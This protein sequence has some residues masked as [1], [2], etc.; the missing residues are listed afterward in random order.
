MLIQLLTEHPLAALTIVQSTP[1]WV[2]GLLAGL[3]LLGAS[4]LRQRRVRLTRIT[5]LPLGMAITSLFGLG[6]DL[7]VTAW[8]APALGVWLLVAAAVLLVTWRTRAP[9]GACYEPATRRIQLPGST[10]PL[11]IIMAIFLIKYS[12][13]V[14]LALQPALRLDPGFALGLAALYGGLSGLLAA[15]SAA[16]WR[17]ATQHTHA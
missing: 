14:E 1:V 2:W 4:Q 11:L 17:L 16:I 3:L 13:G 9:D 7:S 10:V 12:V 6:K 15:R 5:L 8:L